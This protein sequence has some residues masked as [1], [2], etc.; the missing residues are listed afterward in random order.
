EILNLL[1]D[2]YGN[3][4]F[5]AITNE[6][7]Y[8]DEDGDQQPIDWSEFDTVNTSFTLVNDQLVITDS[9]G[10]TVELDVE[11]LANNSTFIT[12]ITSNQEFID[13][14]INMLE[15]EYGNVFFGDVSIEGDDYTDVL[16]YYDDNGDAQLI[17]VANTLIQNLIDNTTQVQELKNILGDTIVEGDV[18]YTGDTI[19]GLAVIS[20]KGTTSIGTHTAET[21]GVDVDLPA[22][23]T[24]EGVVGIS[25]YQNGNL[26][27]TTVTDVE[28][29]GSK[30]DFNIGVGTFYQVLPQ[31]DY[32][33]IVYATIDE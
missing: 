25:L 19:E 33:V 13:E 6:F 27:T 21:S 23:V 17:D 15:G 11:E 9:S 8:I 1:E 16:Y 28:I 18:V 32:E 10:D 24:L 5:D 14:I 30:I 3:V 31:G 29:T 4:Y 22:G 20:Y 2:E 26:I 12:T 7:Y